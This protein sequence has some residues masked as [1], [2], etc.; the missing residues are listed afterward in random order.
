MVVP[1]AAAAAAAVEPP[2]TQRMRGRATLRAEPLVA[3]ASTG[4]EASRFLLAEEKVPDAGH[5]K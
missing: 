2:L 5:M 1:A 3:V 4:A